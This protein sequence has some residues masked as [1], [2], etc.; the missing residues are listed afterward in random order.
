MKRAI[1]LVPAR[2]ADNRRKGNAPNHREHQRSPTANAPFP[3]SLIV[4]DTIFA[5]LLVTIHTH[6]TTRRSHRQ[7]ITLPSYLTSTT[8]LED[9]APQAQGG[10]GGRSIHRTD[11]GARNCQHTERTAE[12]VGICQS[13]AVHFPLWK[14]CQ[15]R[16]GFRHRGTT[17]R[18]SL[19][20]H[21]GI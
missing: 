20:K 14:R 2:S 11:H 18:Q 4:L 19:P 10:G 3:F 7:P 21:G 6:A 16:R 8:Q 12:Y 1:R 13:D 9:A 17:L 5:L 15:N